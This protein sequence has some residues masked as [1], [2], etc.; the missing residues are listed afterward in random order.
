[1]SKAAAEIAKSR[2]NYTTMSP[3]EKINIWVRHDVQSRISRLITELDSLRLRNQK[4][5]R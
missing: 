4:A 1:M 3:E 2:D 5:T